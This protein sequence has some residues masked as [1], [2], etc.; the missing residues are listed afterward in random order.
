MTAFLSLSA[1]MAIVAI[2]LVAVPLIRRKDDSAPVAALLTA[3]VLPVA[4]VF[5]YVAVSDYPWSAPR[6]VN[7]WVS[8][9]DSYLAQ[10]RFGEARD[11]FRQAMKLDGE[12]DDELSMAYVEAAVLADGA[13]LQGEAGEIID[14]VLQR[15]P[16]NPKALWYGGIMSMGRGDVATARTRW[17]RLLE[18]SPPPAVRRILE[19][20]L[21]EL[22]SAGAAGNS[23]PGVAATGRTLP[24]RV[25]I[26]P[27]LAAKVGAGATLFLIARAPGGSGPPLAVVRR[28]AAQLP[29]DIEIS[30]SDSM[31]PGRS[32]AG[33]DTVQLTARVA[34]GG[35][36]VASA[37]D[38]YGEVLWRSDTSAKQPVEIVIDRVVN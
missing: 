37:G 7:G 25:R 29:L 23:A 9:G 27:E 33:L 15:N 36:A 13:S 20:Q 19:Q 1:L 11:A 31:L 14:E 17:S 5:G 34:N 2:A 4:L 22:D 6:D 8:L 38:V 16:L 30:E 32:I 10:E 3:L 35:N 28:E 24:V 26:A 21:A 12:G 18:L